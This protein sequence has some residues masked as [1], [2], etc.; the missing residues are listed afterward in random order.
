[1]LSAGLPPVSGESRERLSAA[2]LVV[3]DVPTEASSTCLERLRDEH[4]LALSSSWVISNNMADVVTGRLV[5][6]KTVF[7]GTAPEADVMP[8][9]EVADLEEA[10]AIIL[11]G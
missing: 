10:L 8:H 5:N 4:T 6:A 7:V 1:M 3:L 11:D 2:G 9:Y